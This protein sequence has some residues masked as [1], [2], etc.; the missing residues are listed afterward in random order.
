MAWL[1]K[2]GQRYRINLDYQGR[3][4]SRS[5]KTGDKREAQALL[6]GCDRSLP[7]NFGEFSLVS[8]K[9]VHSWAILN[10]GIAKKRHPNQAWVVACDPS[11][12]RMPDVIFYHF[13]P[14]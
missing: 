4:F 1:E 5:L 6:K 11:Q 3:H 7:E 10:F 9:W 14:V 2:R 12:E 8:E 13:E